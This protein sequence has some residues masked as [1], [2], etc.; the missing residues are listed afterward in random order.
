[1]IFTYLKQ[2]LRRYTFEAPKIRNWVESQVQGKTVLNLF[3]G[4][5]RLRRC[6][7]IT[8]D[9]DTSLEMDYHVDALELVKQLSAVH[10]LFDVVILD[11]PYRF[12]NLDLSS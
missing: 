7:E 2:P 11:P 10:K 12:S 5:T 4:P 9:L 8:N 3:A 1:M 6:T